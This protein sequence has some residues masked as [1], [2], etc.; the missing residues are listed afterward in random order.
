MAAVAESEAASASAPVPRYEPSWMYDA[1][2]EEMI[3]HSMRP[4]T[5]AALD[6]DA[7]EWCRK[8]LVHHG[9]A[10]NA[11]GHHH[12]AYAWFSCA[13][14]LSMSLWKGSPII[15]HTRRSVGSVWSIRFSYEMRT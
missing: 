8:R 14:G 15:A 13:Y 12:M 6:A 4:P 9:H 2:P 11:R 7:S 3:A 1:V 5:S 10:A